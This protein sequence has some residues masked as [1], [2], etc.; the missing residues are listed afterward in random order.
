MPI[1][2]RT[3][4]QLRIESSSGFSEL[5]NLRTTVR[6]SSAR[7]PLRF[8]SELQCEQSPTEVW[9]YFLDFKQWP[10][11]SPICVECRPTTSGTIIVGSVLLIRF[12]VLWF[13]ISVNAPIVDYE[14]GRSITWTG[15]KFGLNA[16]HSY[17][18]VANSTGTQM[19]N[20]EIIFCDSRFVRWLIKGWY[21]A[22]NLSRASLEGIRR[23]VEKQ[24]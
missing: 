18:F 17:R 16:I 22:T 1:G 14:P 12:R 20:E 24:N 3:T 13:T 10:N 5:R 6:V 15:K 8:Y 4:R 9:D 2:I 11:W 23:E 21:R 19:S 7:E